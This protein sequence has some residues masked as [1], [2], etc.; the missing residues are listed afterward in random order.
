[1]SAF[2]LSNPIL[3]AAA[4]GIATDP[5]V[6]QNRARAAVLLHMGYNTL[7]VY[8][9]NRGPIFVLSLLG[10]IGSGYMLKKR[11]NGEAR[12]LY[13]IT[14]AASLGTAWFTRPDALRSTPPPPPPGVPETG[15]GTTG[16]TLAWLDQ[17]AAD[18]T[19]EDPTWEN[20]TWSRLSQDLGSNTIPPA[21]N[22]L[23][24]K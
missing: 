24:I 21:V 5:A 22:A 2:D 1:M 23:L 20:E 11:K 19:T 7:D 6:A 16:R 12:A 13:S 14:L 3:V 18:N 9:Q 8:E 17:K 4:Q 10:A 15:T